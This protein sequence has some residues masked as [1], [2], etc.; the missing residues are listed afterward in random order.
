[1]GKLPV[2]EK[3]LLEHLESVFPDTVP[4]RSEPDRDIWCRVGNVE[5]IRHLRN[6]YDEQQEDAFNLHKDE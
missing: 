4:D 1:M 5:V 6:L 3:S 2:I